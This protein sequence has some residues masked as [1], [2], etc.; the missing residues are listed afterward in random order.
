[1]PNALITTILI[2]A[3]SVLFLATV[4]PEASDTIV[5]D[6]PPSIIVSPQIPEYAF[7]AGEQVPLNSFSVRENFD[8]EL[9]INTYRHSSSILY[10]KRASRWFPIIE[11]ILEENGIPNDFK[12]LAVI[13]S[14][15]TQAVSPSGASG[16]WQ[17]MKKTAP[18]YG[19][20]ITQTVDERYH[21]EKSTH[22]ACLYLQES[23]EKFGNWALSA[24]SYNM[25]M[26]GVEMRLESQGVE[27]Y[28]D[29]HLNSE[30]G[31]YVYRILAVK[32]V[33]SNPEAY[34]FHLTEKDLYHPHEVRKISITTSIENLS[35]FALKNGSNYRELKELNPWLRQDSLVVATGKT[36]SILFPKMVTE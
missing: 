30:T 18:E 8:K 12:Y 2:S 26:S 5:N 23:Y 33:L 20:E 31:R 16:F 4:S 17:F 29:L 19:L 13:E 32:A 1:M 36:Y 11:P 28:W 9:I 22:A 27:S 15:L 10:L 21:V 35:E 6:I 24:A 14:G 3:S 25:G 34:G 7:L